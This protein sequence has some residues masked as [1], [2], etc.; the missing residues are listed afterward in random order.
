MTLAHAETR[1]GLREV[2]TGVARLPGRS[3]EP[4]VIAADPAGLDPT[5]VAALPLLTRW[6]QVFITGA[7]VSPDELPDRF[8]LLVAP[9]RET[10]V[11]AEMRV[12]ALIVLGPVAPDVRCPVLVIAPPGSATVELITAY[13]CFA[14]AGHPAEQ[15]HLI[16]SFLRDP[17]RYPAGSTIPRARP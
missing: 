10:A 13:V 4:V 12:S 7:D 17:R 14:E 6:R 16:D 8:A 11:A 2:K 9:G 3:L 15:A 5:L 1:T